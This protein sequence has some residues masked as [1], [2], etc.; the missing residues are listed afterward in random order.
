MSGLR[1]W[2]DAAWEAT[3]CP[4]RRGEVS[5]QLRQLDDIPFDV[6]ADLFARLT[7]EALIN[8]YTTTFLAPRGRA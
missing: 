2:F 6:L 4:L 7:P 5:V 8:A 3:G 1:D